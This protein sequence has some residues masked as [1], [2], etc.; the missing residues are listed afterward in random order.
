MIFTALRFFL[1]VLIVSLINPVNAQS[2]DYA[3]KKNISLYDS[4]VSGIHIFPGLWRPVFKTEQ[5]AWISPPW[6]N[7]GFI[8]EN[9]PKATEFVWLDFPKAIFSGEKLLFISHINPSLP[10]LYNYPQVIQSPWIQIHDGI[11][12]TQ[13]LPNGIKF[14]GTV[15]KENSNTITVELWIKNETDS[16]V[17]NIQ[18]LTCAYLNPIEEFSEK[19]NKNKFVHIPG[20]GWVTL[21][22]ALLMSGNDSKYAVGWGGSSHKVS[23]LPV[24]VAISKE[25]NRLIAYTWWHNTGALWGNAFHPSFNAD[26][27]IPDLASG[28]EYTVKGSIIFFEG[29]LPQFETYFRDELSK[30]R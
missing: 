14:G 6:L 25:Q 16:I 18:L 3:L 9:F 23:D 1:V 24:I 11:Q 15:T 27:F 10:S 4:A 21:E 28:Q 8:W 17:G 30:K 20:E 22:R 13:H 26:P 2:N 19:S 7:K 12:Y 5:I 29:T